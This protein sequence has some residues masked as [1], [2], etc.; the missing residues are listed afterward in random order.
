MKRWFLE[1]GLLTV[2]IPG[3]IPIPM[4]LKLFII[5]A[6]AFQVNPFWFTLVMTL[7]R[8]PRYFGLAWLGKRLGAQ[9]LPYLAHHVW[10]LLGLAAALFLVLYLAI[11]LIDRRRKIRQAVSDSD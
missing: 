9:T 8:I 4:P 2:F 1:Y 5:A 11:K 7:A 10:Q 6:G 3:M